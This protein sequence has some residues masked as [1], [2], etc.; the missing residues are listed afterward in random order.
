MKAIVK[1]KYIYIE[2]TPKE[3]ITN[4]LWVK[5]FETPNNHTEPI[6]NTDIYMG[7]NKY[8]KPNKGTNEKPNYNT[9]EIAWIKK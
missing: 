2:P 1:R 9:V 7:V 5:L 8:I 4:G 3:N 6:A